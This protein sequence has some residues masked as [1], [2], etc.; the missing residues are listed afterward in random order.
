M[1]KYINFHVIL[2]INRQKGFSDMP[3]SS[4]FM[5]RLSPILPQIVEKFGTPFHIYDQKGIE[6]T[7]R[8][9]YKSFSAFHGFKEY[10]A[11]K[12]LPN[13]AILSI[14][15]AQECG[16]DCSSPAE[17]ILSKKTGASGEQIM[18]TSNNTTKEQFAAAMD[19]GAIVNLDDISLLE[20]LPKTPGLICFRY[21][22]GPA[23]DGN[24]IIGKPEEAKYGV[25][26]DQILTAYEKAREMGA[27][28]FGLHTMV[29]SNELDENYIS[30][31]VAMLLELAATL[32]EKLNIQ[33]EFINMGGGIGIPYAPAQKTFDLN[34]MAQKAARLFE[35]FT[36]RYG[37]T[38][39]LFMESGRYVTGPHGVLVTRVI[40]HKHIYRDYVGVD[41]SMAALMRPG[42]YGAY[43]H[44]HIHGKNPEKNLKTVD[45]TGALCENND[46]FAI[47]RAL[48][49][50][51]QGDILLIHDTGAHGHAMGFNYNGQLRPQELL[52]TPGG[53]VRRIRRTET[54][55]DYFATLDFD[56]LE[57]SPQRQ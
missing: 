20:K 11:V 15:N 13:P 57:I 2:T 56:H 16:F 42:M 9:L 36:D 6:D 46:K 18:F 28:R 14:L 17:L 53:N 30:Q 45:I 8:N 5:H 29:A 7:C 3:M 21:N 27:T 51:Q 54:L 48:P 50:T 1:T 12:A 22:P 52:L 40:N 35:E 38:P 41:A 32:D 39:K 43:H 10:F 49:E 34:G 37:F 25:S 23:R 19:L 26:R 24:S 55:D 33:C 31:T 4:D 47:Q 44:I